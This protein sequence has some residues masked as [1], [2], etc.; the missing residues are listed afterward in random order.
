MP[1]RRRD[2]ADRI[3]DRKQ[4][5][6]PRA[7]DPLSAMAPLLRV[8]PEFQAVCRFASPW[9][10]P[11]DAEPAGWAQFHIVTKGKCLLE[12]SD[13][14]PLRLEAGDVLL[15]PHGDAHVVRSSARPLGP[16]SPIRIEYGNAI[17]TRTNTEG[18]VA[19]ELI[20]GRLR[21]E[22]A[23]DSFVIATLPDV[24]VLRLGEAPLD[25][26]RMLVR[27]IHDELEGG[28]LGGLAVATDLASALFVQMLRVHCERASDAGA[29]RLLSSLPSAR[30]VSAMLRAPGHDW[31]LDA[32]AAEAHVSRAS[33]VRIFRKTAGVA[34][35][36][37]LT[38]LRLGLARQRLASTE[39]SVARVAAEVGYQSESA[40][41][42][43]FHRRFKTTPG[44]IR[45]SRIT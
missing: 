29:L 27:A 40:F 25:H 26:M 42:R 1:Q 7:Q 37:F 23:T 9:D 31:T 11:H 22:A 34:P 28:R 39:V 43:A 33:L 41:A 17:E 30:A 16:K 4:A 2:F 18:E 10:A 3:N 35:L 21:F 13:G 14:H 38:D 12:R 32:L 8:R 45:A 15:L 44:R 6:P 5:P 24:I 19:T 20:C 36:A